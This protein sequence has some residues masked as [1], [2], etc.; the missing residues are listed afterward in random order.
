MNKSIPKNK[1][2]DFVVVSTD[3]K[4]NTIDGMV[5]TDSSI[6]QRKLQGLV[7]T[8][9]D[10]AAGSLNGT[11]LKDNSIPLSKLE[12]TT[13]SGGGGGDSTSWQVYDKNIA[14]VG[15]YLSHANDAFTYYVKN[16]DSQYFF[17]LGID[18]QIIQAATLYFVNAD[19]SGPMYLNIQSQYPSSFIFP[20]QNQYYVPLSIP[21]TTAITIQSQF[22]QTGTCV[23]M[24]NSAPT[25]MIPL[26][27][28]SGFDFPDDLEAP[29][30][31]KFN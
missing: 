24:T 25:L 3:M 5:L 7:L 22:L 20:Y 10:F 4:D 28:L 18:C 31:P 17:L 16:T 13:A 14:A 12:S 21:T 2:Q 6:P 23:P 9:N 19:C 8:S 11:I 29:C 30:Q 15:T 27:L 26:S 1:F